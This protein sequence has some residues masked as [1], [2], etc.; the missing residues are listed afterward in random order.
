MEHCVSELFLLFGGFEWDWSLLQVCQWSTWNSDIVRAE[1]LIDFVERQE[2]G[3]GE[4]DLIR[5]VARSL[6]IVLHE[7]WH[8]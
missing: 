4:L 2:N 1:K 3:K 6:G 7:T 8:Y 5:N